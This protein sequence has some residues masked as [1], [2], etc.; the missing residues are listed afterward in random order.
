MHRTVLAGAQRRNEG[1]EMFMPVEARSLG[2]L[3]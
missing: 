2:L 3:S 1:V